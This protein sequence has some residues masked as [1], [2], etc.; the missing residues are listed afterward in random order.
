MQSKWLNGS[1][2]GRGNQ[3]NGIKS[4]QEVD[5]HKILLQILPIDFRL[6]GNQSHHHHVGILLW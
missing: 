2:F 1:L 3:K 4:P 5:I 6:H